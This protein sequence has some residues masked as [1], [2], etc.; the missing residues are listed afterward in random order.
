MTERHQVII[1]GGGPVGVGLALDLGLRGVHCV[2]I[3]R[4]PQLSGIPKGQGLSQRTMEHAWRW[5]VA[6][7]LR[8][9]RTM[10]EGHPI[11]QVTVYDN[12]LGD[13][14]SAPPA[15]ELVQDYYAQANERLPQYRTEEVFRDRLAELPG[16]E[17]RLGW[18]ATEVDQDEN[19]ARVVVERDGRREVLEADYVVGCDGG[20]SVVREQADIERSGTDWDELVALVVFRS[21]ELHEALSRFPDRST[22]RVMHPDLLGYWMFFGRVDV[23]A[24]FFFHAPVPP[25]T[26]ADGP[27]IVE[28]LHRAAGFPFALE[29]DHVGFWDL[30]V[31]VA[32][33]YRAGRVFIAG[34]AA[35][36]HPPYGGFGLN[37]GLEDAANLGWKLAATLQGWGG[38]ALLESYS[39]ERQPV[40][41]D[42][43]EDIIGGWIRDDRA[44]LEK[45]RPED[46][47]EEFARAFE[48]AARGFGRRLRSFEP[49]Y[50]G[51]PAVFGPA[52]GVSSAHGE[53]TFVA[54]AGHHLPPR[55]LSSGRSVF[56]ELGA[57]FTLLALDV[58]D[59][60]VALFQEAARALGVPL[61]VLRDTCSGEVVDYGARLVLVRPDQFVAWTGDAAPQDAERVLGRATGA[62]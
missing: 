29:I 55:R 42:V 40:F 27:E 13:F 24:E 26:T 32:H 44:M 16:V 25:G 28:L 23:G 53:H 19:G 4:R 36:T 1:V 60:A 50:E 17:L 9:A 18:R 38:D 49:H 21:P 62:A 41:R 7:R 31:Q 47:R 6:D 54:R 15:R 51:S 57:G 20:H 3:E 11:G 56:E 22:Y 58:D 45:Y 14:W 43:G 59:A 30:R 5:G 10:P 61:T 39:L 52:G 2:V 46:D 35:H 8:A 37:N 33:R 12:L 34:D 48:E